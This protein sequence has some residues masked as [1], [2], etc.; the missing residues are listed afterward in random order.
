MSSTAT[1]LPLSEDL[2]SIIDAA[3]RP[4][5]AHDQAAFLTAVAEALRDCQELGPGVMFRTIKQIQ[6]EF[7]R[8]PGET[9]RGPRLG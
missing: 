5:P 4:L 7:F 1:A 2:T 8:P 9:H 3:A 6:R